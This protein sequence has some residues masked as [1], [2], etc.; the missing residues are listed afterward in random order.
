MSKSHCKTFVITF[1]RCTLTAVT[2][3]SFLLCM[4]LQILLPFWPLKCALCDR[5]QHRN[6][7][8]LFVNAGA[9]MYARILLC[10][11]L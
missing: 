1:I 11:N 2:A 7:K 5:V 9:H 10:S 8:M 6:D 3:L 4:L